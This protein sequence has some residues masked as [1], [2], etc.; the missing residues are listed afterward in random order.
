VRFIFAGLTAAALVLLLVPAGN[1]AAPGAR[2]AV[3]I[4]PE[5]CMGQASDDQ[6]VVY[7]FT[8]KFHCQ[9]CETVER[10]LLETVRKRYSKPFSE[11]FLTM[12]VINVDDPINRHF[13]EK[14]PIVSNSIF[15]VRKV[16]GEISQSRNLESIWEIAQDPK[17]IGLFLEDNLEEY[18]AQ[19]T[20]PETVTGTGEDE[21]AGR[22]DAGEKTGR[23]PDRK[24]EPRGPSGGETGTLN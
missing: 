18:M 2:P 24:T 5:G 10:V 11:G 3:S 4:L 7:Y 12:C 17:A 15:L 21:A 13:L 16:A 20:Q 14:F 23:N 6:V 19:S 9:S 8:R 22:K 1:A